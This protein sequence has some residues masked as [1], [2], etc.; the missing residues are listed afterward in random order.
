MRSLDNLDELSNQNRLWHWGWK[1]AG[2]MNLFQKFNLR[3]AYSNSN[4]MRTN[5][6]RLPRK[7]IEFGVM[8]EGVNI[9]KSGY[10][11]GGYAHY[12]QRNVSAFK[13]Q[14]SST[15]RDLIFAGLSLR[16]R[17]FNIDVQ[18]A[19]RPLKETS[20]ITTLVLVGGNLPF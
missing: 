11:L 16:Q 12:H 8:H 5:Q 15:S 19:K 4:P 1:F 7:N 3:W 13:W 20:D 6:N 17:T 2:H 14:P 9:S 10:R 18:L